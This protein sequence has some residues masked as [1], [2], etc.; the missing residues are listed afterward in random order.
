MDVEARLHGGGC[1]SRRSSIDATCFGGASEREE[2][3]REARRLGGSGLLLT[4][5]LTKNGGRRERGLA[6]CRRLMVVVSLSSEREKRG[7]RIGSVEDSQRDGLM[8]YVFV[9]YGKEEE[10]D[11]FGR[12]K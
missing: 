2:E 9:R 5:K 4:A 12:L 3:E 8:V 1:L 10:K 7:E 6:K 11:R